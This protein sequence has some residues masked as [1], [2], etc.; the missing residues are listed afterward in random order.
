MAALTS[1][2]TKT[3]PQFAG[4]LGMINPEGLGTEDLQKIRD[5]TDK[6]IADLEH[7]YDKP[8]WFK[9]A[10]GFAKP[11]LGGFLA[12]LGSASEAMGENVEQQRE[13]ILPITNL[14]IQR[15]LAGTLLGQKIK[16]RDMFDAWKAS[17]KPMD[18]QTYTSIAALGNGT[19]IAQSAKSFWEQAKGRIG[20]TIQA[21]EGAS[22]YPRL[23]AA[24]KDLIPAMADP[25]ADQATVSKKMAD[26]DKQLDASRPPQTDPA[27]W[28]GM[29]RVDK[30][31]AVAQYQQAQQGIGLTKEGEFRTLHDRST[32]ALPLLS[33]IRDLA[34]GKGLADATIKDENG[35][36]IKV[37]GQQQMQRLLGVFG[38]N[39]LLEI[40]GKAVSDGKLNE[41]F[42]GLD[43]YVRQGMM[44]PETRAK[45][46]ELAKLLA[47]NQVQLRNS[48]VNP[49]D[50]YS[51]LQ[52][53]SQPGI[54][55]SQQALVGI[56]DLMAHGER[57]NINNY[58]YL[59][60]SGVDAR[61][62]ASNEEFH[63]KQGAYSKEHNQIARDKIPYDT[64]HYYTNR[65][66]PDAQPAAQP[67]SVSSQVAPVT[68][69]AT[70]ATAPP[71]TSATGTAPPPQDDIRK[72]TGYDPNK[73][74]DDL[75]KLQPTPGRLTRIVGKN[76]NWVERDAKGHWVDTGEKP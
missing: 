57:N 7:R 5:A 35:K 2:P 33:T 45:F 61:H 75:K 30:M 37:N 13:N 72:R 10:A 34:L 65:A 23:D 38:G 52:Q 55:N 60:N 15:E 4:G 32:Q 9:V 26:V 66:K 42:R 50:A 56:V 49:T 6:G 74:A 70:P 69:Q 20:T 28:S 59:I 73:M 1:D 18:E 76:G 36:D 16:Q 14:K 63:N 22:S 54:G 53:S 17:G 43:Q 51:Q 27:T 48:S 24:W 12:S 25:K 11:Q 29:N 31:A 40:V 58:K 8:N 46:E 71:T 47:A 19:E 64:P 68:K 62:L 67:S 3:D 39:N 21:E 41:M 44:K